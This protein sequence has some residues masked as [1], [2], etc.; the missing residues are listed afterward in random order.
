[1]AEE[2][3]ERIRMQLIASKVYAQDSVFAQAMEI[4]RLETVG[5]GWP[6]IDEYVDHLSRV[7][8]AQVQAVARKYLVPEHLTVAVLDP[9]P[10]D[11]DR[12]R[13]AAVGGHASAR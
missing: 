10:M 7:T 3:L 5:L 2:E 13:R 6:L 8:P 4:G 9:Q 11:D 12:P 1:V